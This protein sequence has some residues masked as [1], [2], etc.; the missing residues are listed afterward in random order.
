MIANWAAIRSAWR[1]E[2]APIE[3]AP[4]RHLPRP[5]P[6]HRTAPPQNQAELLL[7][8]R[9]AAACEINFVVYDLLPLL[10]PQDVFPYGAEQVF[11]GAFL[12]H[13]AHWCPTASLCDLAFAVA[14]EFARAAATAAAEPV[15]KAPLQVGFF[16]LGAD[17]DASV[18]S[19]GLP[20]DAHV[21]AGRGESRAPSLLMVGTVE[22]RKGQ[23][24]ALAAFEQLWAAG[25]AT[26]TWS[27]SASSGWM[28]D[29]PWPQR[30]ERASGKLGERLFWL[31]GVSDE[32][33][34]KLYA[35][36]LRGPA[37]RPRRAKASACR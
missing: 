22:P 11:H 32:M 4:R 23:A 19:N 12:A 14:D 36:L 2:D 24:Q 7:D 10:L 21:G 20:A 27:S 9:R 1:C 3:L 37:G 6:V 34:L 35:E 13:G 30:L 18:P 29:E 31:A 17:I 28:V 26:P 16:H 25:V 8:M 33:L 15:R 5:R